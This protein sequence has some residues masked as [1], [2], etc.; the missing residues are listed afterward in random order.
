MK[1]KGLDVI[2]KIVSLF[3][4]FVLFIMICMYIGLLIGPKLISKDNVSTIVNDMD[5]KEILNTN[6]SD[7][8]DRL[9]TIA[10][11][12]NIDRQIVDG[13]INSNEFKALISEYYGDVAHYLSSGQEGTIITADKIVQTVDEVLDRTAQEL[14]ITLTEEQH[15]NILVEVEENSSEIS[16]MFPTYDEMKNEINEEDMNVIRILLGDSS[17]IVLFVMIIIVIAIIA[18]VRWSIYRF[19]IWTGVTTV[20]A[21]GVFASL[22]GLGNVAMKLILEEEYSTA[23]IQLVKE[24]IFGTFVNYGLV[25]LLIG[26]IQ[27]IYYFMLRNKFNKNE[28]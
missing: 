4:C 11:N 6:D 26:T 13:I 1:N 7:S 27:I 20:L 24:N 16:N 12:N 15:D 17:K 25:V 23:T 8:L 9:Y 3:L 2:S 21:G 28:A 5:M 14:G 10:D 22:G 19:A 18:I